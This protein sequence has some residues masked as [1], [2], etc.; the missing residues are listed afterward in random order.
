MFSRDSRTLQHQSATKV[1]DEYSQA[2]SGELL[3]WGH[4]MEF[5]NQV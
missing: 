3:A 4:P 5:Q 1:T 2:L